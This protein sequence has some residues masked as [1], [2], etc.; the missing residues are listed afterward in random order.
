[1]D[2][3]SIKIDNLVNQLKET[4]PDAAAQIEQYAQTADNRIKELRQIS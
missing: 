4:A 2:S 1:M 3:I